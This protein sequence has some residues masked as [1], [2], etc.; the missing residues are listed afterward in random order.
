MP[1]R[2]VGPTDG[3]AVQKEYD[4]VFDDA[5]DFIK[6]GIIGG[7]G[8]FET[9]EIAKEKEVKVGLIMW[10]E[11]WGEDQRGHVIWIGGAEGGG[12]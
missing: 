11:L 6:S 5:I 2:Q 4:F 10:E 3:S 8:D 1:P 7:E 9:A 12:R